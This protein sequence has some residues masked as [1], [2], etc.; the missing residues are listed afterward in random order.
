M[1]SLATAY[2]CESE[3]LQALTQLFAKSLKT[4]P[5][6]RRILDFMRYAAASPNRIKAP[7][8]VLRGLSSLLTSE[9]ADPQLAI[10]LFRESLRKVSRE[11][12]LLIEAKK[13]SWNPTSRSEV[14]LNGVRLPVS[15][16]DV[17]ETLK[18]QEEY[19][20]RGFVKARL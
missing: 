18:L 15:S 10:N 9:Y 12:L 16:I 5:E 6:E 20:L 19:S 13:V 1:S 3:A 17:E 11:T 2:F 4:K 14:T 7:F 8:L